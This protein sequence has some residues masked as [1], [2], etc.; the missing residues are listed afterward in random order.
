[1]SLEQAKA[2]LARVREDPSL[3]HA[4][5]AVHSEDKQAALSEVVR[6]GAEHGFEFAPEHYE[7]ATQDQIQAELA[8]SEKE[9]SSQPESDASGLLD[10]DLGSDFD[11]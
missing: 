11:F 10:L 5:H 9:V 4:I 6:I 2:F 8:A 1:M 7:Q 3:E